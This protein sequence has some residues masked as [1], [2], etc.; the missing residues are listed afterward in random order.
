[1]ASCLMLAAL[2]RAQRRPVMTVATTLL[3]AGWTYGCVRHWLNW[4][5]AAKASRALVADLVE[6]SRDPATQEIVIANV[7]FRVRGGSVAGDFSAALVVAGGRPIPVR[8]LAYVS[9]PS[10]RD[11]FISDVEFVRGKEP[12]PGWLAL[13]IWKAP[14]AHF[15]GPRPASSEQRVESPYGW[16]RWGT[17]PSDDAISV[18]VFLEVKGSPGRAAYA[19]SRGCLVRLF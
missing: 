10:A 19:W 16:V 15:V 6:A 4:G 11:D 17:L 7:P 13:S 18:S 14:F 5:E 12:P 9:Y 8:G 3:V 2:L 1:A